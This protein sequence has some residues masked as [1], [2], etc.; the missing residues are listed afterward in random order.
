MPLSPLIGLG[1]DVLQ[2]V[3][4]NLF[5]SAENRRQ[6]EWSSQQYQQQKNDNLEFW[7]MQNEYNDPANMMKRYQAAGINPNLVTGGG[8][9]NSASP[10]QTV[11]M[12]R[13]E[14]HANRI[15]RTG[16]MDAIYDYNI[17]KQTVDNLKAQNT[18]LLEDAAYKAALTENVKASTESRT[19]DLGFK[20]DTRGL[21]LQAMQE[22]VRQK[23]VGTDLALNADE[24]AALKNSSDLSEA[25]A[26]IAN[27]KIDQLAKE[28]GIRESKER[29]EQIRASVQN[30]I[31]DGSIKDFEIFL[32]KRGL[33]KTDEPYYRLA[34]AILKQVEKGKSLGDMNHG[35]FNYLKNLFT[36]K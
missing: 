19:F 35:F 29:I 14:T 33:T 25:I 16:Y 20:T 32:N 1:L 24:R 28:Q 26:R 12:K 5:T 21:S 13:P 27:M 36:N 15:E 23:K 30:A 11:D 10:I 8:A 31:K 9:A 4:N 18:V 3:G 22:S 2:N 6:R 17:K 34:D 7:R